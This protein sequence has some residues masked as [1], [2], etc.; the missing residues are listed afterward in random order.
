MDFWSSAALTV[1]DIG[2][3]A[4]V[5][6]FKVSSTIVLNN[7]QARTSA[8]EKDDKDA[9]ATTSY[10]SL[11]WDWLEDALGRCKHL[12][13]ATHLYNAVFASLFTYDYNENLMKA[14][15]VF[16]DEVV[17]NVQELD[18]TNDQGRPYL[19][20]S[21]RYLFL[22]YHHLQNR[23]KR[24]GKVPS[25][26]K[27]ARWIT[28]P[29]YSQNPLGEINEHGPWSDKEH[30]IFTDLQV[31]GDLMEET[32]LS[33]LLSCWLCIFV[34]PIK[35]QNSI[36]PGTFKI[37]SSMANG[38]SF[39]LSTLV[40]A[41]IYYG[42]NTISSS[43]TPS[44]F[45]ASFAI[46]YV[47]AWVGHLFRSNRI[48]HDNLS[49]PL[50][51]KYSGV[52][53][54]SPFSEFPTRKHIR[55]TT[56]FLCHGT[57]FKKSH[58]QIVIDNG[59]LSIQKFDYFMSLHLSYLSLRCE[60]QHIVE[61]YS[62]HRFCWCFGFHQDIP[63]DL[64]EEIH[65]SSLKDLYQ[66]YQSFTCCNTNSKP[67]VKSLD[68]KRRKFV[69]V[70]TSSK[71]SIETKRAPLSSLQLTKPLEVSVFQAKAHV[72]SMRRKGASMLGDV[73]LNR[74]SN[75]SVDNILPQAKVH[76][77]YSGVESLGVD[78]QHLRKNVDKYCEGIADFLKMKESL[79]KRPS[80]VILIQCKAEVEFLLSEASHEKASLK[81]ELD[82]VRLRMADLQTDLV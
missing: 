53:Y 51:T 71:F 73:L 40:L 24:Q 34:F 8:Q 7:M 47:Y 60:D 76:E 46:H 79:N 31:E 28:I 6:V 27:P 57:T 15:C 80:P 52:G 33:A 32:Y 43:P 54:A 10:F 48:T 16:H 42:L 23:L 26:S 49:N 11:Y 38:R 41:S 1:F 29:K 12:L 62:P 78:P 9:K 68:L 13:D 58:D 65:T 82:I 44:K 72:S 22:A 50:M 66:F 67:F 74:L 37:T 21:C 17:P 55:T 4:S 14:F 25:F 75:I 81:T 3:S 63:S 56:D 36:C 69:D 39:G 35:D 59:H 70:G 19:P 20:C 45:G 5:F 2:K 77:I 61:A 64:K 18:G 30:G